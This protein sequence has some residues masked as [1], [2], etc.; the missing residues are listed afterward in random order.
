MELYRYLVE[1]FVI[2]NSA[3][4]KKKDFIMKRED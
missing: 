2:Q 3:N 1:D 4:F